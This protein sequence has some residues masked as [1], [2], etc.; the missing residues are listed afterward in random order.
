MAD[1]QHPT[2]RQQP[3]QVRQGDMSRLLREIDAQV[4]T[5][6]HLE[7][8]RLSREKER[9][10]EVTLCESHEPSH[11]RTSAKPATFSQQIAATERFH[12]RCRLA[13]RARAVVSFPA[14][15]HSS[16]GEIDVLD[17]AYVHAR[18]QGGGQTMW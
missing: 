9:I 13:K 8:R 10:D 16:P 15:C 18:A 2:R 6:D 4:A 17:L 5:E 12:P 14:A 7:R 1:V 3:M 11:F